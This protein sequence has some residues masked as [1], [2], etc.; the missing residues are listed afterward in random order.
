M[1]TSPTLP[2]LPKP[3]TCLPPSLPPIAQTELS[4]LPCTQ[5]SDIG[6]IPR[7]CTRARAPTTSPSAETGILPSTDPNRRPGMPILPHLTPSSCS[8]SIAQAAHPITK[9]WMPALLRL[10]QATLHRE[11]TNQ[12]LRRDAGSWMIPARGRIAN[13]GDDRE[14][15]S[16]GGS[17]WMSPSFGMFVRQVQ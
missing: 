2:T 14:I 17:H 10:A 4:L 12:S 16:L 9:T 3:R 11:A 15:G 13:S 7:S 6:P 1:G 8:C 5:T